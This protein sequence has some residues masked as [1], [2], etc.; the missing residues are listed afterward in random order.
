MPSVIAAVAAAMPATAASAPPAAGDTAVDH[1]QRAQT[2]TS[3]SGTKSPD[4][5]LGAVVAEVAATG[6]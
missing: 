3:S 6:R 5:A 4:V 2:S 1:D